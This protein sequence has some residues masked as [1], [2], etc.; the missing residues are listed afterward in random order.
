MEH[1]IE[2]ADNLIP[3][4]AMKRLENVSN[5][6]EFKC[7]G[8]VRNS[9]RMESDKELENLY[10]EREKATSDDGVEEVEVKIAETLLV[11]QREEYET[12]LEQ[13]K[14]IQKSK[15]RSAAIFKLKEKVLGSKKEGMES[16]SMKDPITGSILY[17]PD[18]LKEASEAY[19]SNLL[20]NR[21]P[22]VGYEQG[23]ITLRSLHEA[24][25]SEEISS[26]VFN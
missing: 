3:N 14:N 18:Q 25:I 9:M 1:I 7:F 10:S 17:D 23:L 5:K 19:L 8:K 21:E 24:R 13:L 12:K 6:I 15:G 11:K 26:E 4:E 22:K 16:V 20:T 2:S